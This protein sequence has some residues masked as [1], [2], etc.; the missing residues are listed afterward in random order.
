MATLLGPGATVAPGPTATPAG[1]ALIV[2]SGAQPF[3]SVDTVSFSGTLRTR[4]YSADPGNP[5][6]ATGLTFT[7]LLTNNGPD[8]LERLVTINYGGYLTDVGVNL[9]LVP[10]A[11]PIA[12][13]RSAN[14]KVVGWDYTGGPGIGPGGNST[15]LVIHTDATQFVPATNSVINGSVAVV[16][17]F[18]PLPIPEPASMGLAGIALLGL[19]ARRRSN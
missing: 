14:G 13:D 10:G 2:D 18:G 9:A 4:V 19:V 7:F 16:P 17:S 3:T 15:L 5:F 1:A 6:G 8:A 11:L 12:V